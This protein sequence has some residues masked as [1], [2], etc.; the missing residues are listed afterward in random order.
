MKRVYQIELSSPEA[1]VEIHQRYADGRMVRVPTKTRNLELEIIDTCFME[2]AVHAKN[3]PDYLSCIRIAKQMQSL[4]EN[5]QFVNF[6]KIDI[7]N[8]MNGFTLTATKRPV[9]WARC[10]KFFEQ[11]NSP[12]EI[13]IAEDQ[14]KVEEQKGN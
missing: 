12:K 14:P 5:V 10:L 7:E 6:N 11:V 4:P 2:L 3:I 8:L 13:E 9:N 1:T